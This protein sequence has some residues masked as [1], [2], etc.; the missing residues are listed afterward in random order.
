MRL[1]RATGPAL[2]LSL[3]LLAGACGDDSSDTGAEPSTESAASETPDA[4]KP[5]E[6]VDFGTEPK[7]RTPPAN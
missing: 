5:A 6:T 7:I 1:T 4:S 3:V 2:G